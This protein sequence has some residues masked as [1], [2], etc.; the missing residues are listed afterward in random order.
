MKPLEKS[1]KDAI[2]L[3]FAVGLSKLMDKSDIKSWKHLA[4]EAGM[5]PSHV[6]KIA[7]GKVDVALTTNIALTSAF[8]ISYV[9]L[10]AAYQNVTDADV[11]KFLEKIDIQKKLKGKSKLPLLVKKRPVRKKNG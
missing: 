1:D 7:S 9:E 5:E 8:G 4:R 11:Q 6:Q 3:R 2:K 10:A